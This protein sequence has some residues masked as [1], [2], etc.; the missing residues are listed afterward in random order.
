MG[1]IDNL[2]NELQELIIERAR[3]VYSE[4]VIDHWLHPR[5]ARPLENA[6][7]HARYT[8][9]CGDTMEIFIRVEGNIIQDAGFTT[10]GCITSI[11]CGSMAV[12]EARGKNVFS[13]MEISQDDI[14]EKLGGLPEESEHCA[15]LASDTLHKAV[16]DY[17][18]MK[19]EPWKKLYR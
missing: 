13:A 17:L 7:G 5:G 3:K 14:L 16:N 8:G 2:A 9:P 1:D 10:D 4:T 18:S 6:D 11:V 12:Q 15:L 19:K